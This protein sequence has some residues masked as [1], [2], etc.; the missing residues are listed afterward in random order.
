MGQGD[1]LKFLKGK[2]YLKIN[3]IALGV[4]VRPSNV[5]SQIRKLWNEG[6]LDRENIGIGRQE[7]YKYKLKKGDKNWGG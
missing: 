5:S 4:D 7:Y 6:L 3:E 2:D 1:L